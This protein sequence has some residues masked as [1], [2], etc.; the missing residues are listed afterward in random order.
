M[1]GADYYFHSPVNDP[2]DS[3]QGTKKVLRGYIGGDRQYALTMFTVTKLLSGKI[4][5][6]QM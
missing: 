1:T 3:A 5:K 2:V 6:D 4:D